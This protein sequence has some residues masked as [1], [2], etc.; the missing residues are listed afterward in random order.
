VLELIDLQW[1]V[2][3]KSSEMLL[4]VLPML[5]EKATLIKTEPTVLIVDD[6]LPYVN[7]SP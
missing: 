7:S 2:C 4:K 1:D 5:P 6:S 3:S